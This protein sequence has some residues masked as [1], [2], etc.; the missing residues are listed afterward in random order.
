MRHHIMSAKRNL[1]GEGIVRYVRMPKG[2]FG[3]VWQLAQA[4]ILR[5]PPWCNPLGS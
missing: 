5:V 4:T 3:W 1:L 2:A